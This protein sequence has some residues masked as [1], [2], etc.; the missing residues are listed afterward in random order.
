MIKEMNKTD[1]ELQGEFRI[2]FN[3]SI[4]LVFFISKTKHSNFLN[5]YQYI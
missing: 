2:L 3:P 5:A 4:N 1:E